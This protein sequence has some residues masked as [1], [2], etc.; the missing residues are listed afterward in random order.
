MPAPVQERYN[1][2]ARGSV[3]G[4]SA[5]K[6]RKRVKARVEEDEDEGGPS[7]STP[8]VDIGAGMS[9]KKKKRLDSYIAKKLKSETRLSTLQLLASLAPSAPTS[10]SLLSSAT[11]GQNPLKPS[12]AKE[13]SEKQEDKLVRRGM[14]R[15]SKRNGYGAESESEEGR[16]T[17]NGKGKGKERAVEVITDGIRDAEDGVETTILP[18]KSDDKIKARMQGKGKGR[19]VLPKKANWNPTL[20]ATQ[21][22]KESSSDFDSSD[23]ANDSLEEEMDVIPVEKAKSPSPAGRPPPKAI[24]TALAGALKKSADGHIVQ[25]RVESRRSGKKLLGRNASKRHVIVEG[26]RDEAM[27]EDEDEDDGDD[28][29]DV[30]DEDDD[31][32]DDGDGDDDDDDD[33]VE[34][35]EDEDSEM[36]GEEEEDEPAPVKKRAF[37]FK[38]WALKQMGQAVPSSSATAPDLTAQTTIAA[39]A[40]SSHAPVTTGSFVGPLGEAIVTPN[41]TLLDKGQSSSTLR[42]TITRRASVSETRM[43][44]PILAEEQPIMEAILMHPVVIICGE[45]GS[46]KTTQVPQMLYEAGF[47]YKGSDNPGMIA[48]TQPR[49]VAAVSLAVRVKSELNLA[50]SSAVVAHQIRYS[51]T[52]SPETCIKFMTDGVL[53]R[54]LASDFLLSK[55][56][57]VVVDEA[58]ERGVNTDVLVGVLSRVARL[59][60]RK[61]REE[62]DSSVKPLRIVIMSATLRV[63]DF[64]NNTTLFKTPPPVIHI[65]ARQHPVTIH[66]SRKTESDY[67]GEAYKKISKIHA[68]LPAGGI[69]VFLTGQGEIQALCKK[70]EQQYGKKG[71]GGDERRVDKGNSTK[72][73]ERAF[74]QEAED[75]ELGGTNDLAADVDDGAADSD[76]DGLDSDDEG[77]NNLEIDEATDTPMHVLPLYSLLPN[78]Q[79][80]LVF[81]PPPEGSRLVIVSTNVAETSLTIPGIRYVVDSGR[82][83]ERQYDPSTG[84]QSF[85]VSWISKASSQQRAGRAGR[86]GPGHCY[87]LYSSALY[88][89]YFE[90]FPKP[91]IL[92]MP[93]EGVVLQMKSMNIDAVVNFPFPTPPDRFSLKKA[94]DLLIHLGALEPP[95]NTRM[96]NGKSVLG[97]QGGQISELGKQMAGFPVTPRFAKMLAFGRQHDCLPFVIAIVACLSVGDPFLHEQ[98][99]E[100][101][102][103]EDEE[104]EVE[105]GDERKRERGHL[106]NQELREKEERKDIRRKLF[107]AHQQFMSL[108]EGS[109]DM[110]KMLAAVGAYE[111]N[112]GPGFCQKNFLRNKAMEEIHQLRRQISTIAKVPAQKLLP[113]SANQ[114]KIIRQIL[115]AGFIDQVAVRQDIFL[116]KSAGAAESTRGIPYRAVGLGSEP[117]YIHPTSITFHRSPPEFIIFQEITK[118]AS[119]GKVWLKG[120]T[121][122]NPVW[123]GSLGKSLCSFSRPVE[124]KFAKREVGSGSGREGER[125]VVVVPHF[126]DLGVDLPP[127][128][129]KQRREGTRWVLCE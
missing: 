44:L 80:M 70:L 36:D 126:K 15:V 113:P 17:P 24:S 59:R 121:K 28:E 58:H 122:I 48:V 47:G 37:G 98:A 26:E 65:Q 27:E 72:E 63:S 45:T 33:V 20:L 103:D 50:V 83:K 57:V 91:E 52:T 99:I 38:D 76:P 31:D 82:A 118:N 14:E 43:E 51:S 2:K 19:G 34:D 29:E 42:P 11:L 111:Y 64:A 78:D 100:N 54:E 68:R 71:K 117:V 102:A 123:L 104:D 105:G 35:E 5:H 128:K 39:K 89:D 66:F 110:F 10:S 25:P 67:V 84:V 74:D 55:Y 92:R 4:G 13:R 96:I 114:L 23:S 97:S 3:A 40:K 77:L 106:R 85:Q 109:S 9:S 8:V 129:M 125:D 95:Q 116:K 90:A 69:L 62:A 56:S 81:K 75:V 41:S 127:I 86:T 115:T 73:E 32:E 101:G 88:E 87:R 61:W 60:E 18:S 53:L 112:P 12:S 79:Q 94:E 46:G 6:K 21:P 108:G 7:T 124:M 93:I 49:R 22:D 30:D 119:T 1:A 16:G 107:K 120:I